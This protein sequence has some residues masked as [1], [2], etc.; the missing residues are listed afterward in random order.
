MT[1]PNNAKGS[2][3]KDG[4]GRYEKG[5]NE[6]RKNVE[7]E[8]KNIGSNGRLVMASGVSPDA[9]PPA[10]DEN[11]ANEG[12]PGA[13]STTTTTTT[14]S[15]EQGRGS[16]DETTTTAR[17]TAGSAT[18]GSHRPHSADETLVEAQMVVQSDDDDDNIDDADVEASMNDQVLLQETE[19]QIRQR[20]LQEEGV[21]VDDVVVMKDDNIIRYGKGKGSGG[22]QSTNKVLYL[23]TILIVIVVAAIVVPTTVV[24]LGNNE[25]KKSENSI[26]F[27]DLTFREQV[28]ETLRPMYNNNNDNQDRNDEGENESKGRKM[29]F[30]NRPSID[31]VHEIGT[32]QNLAF[33]WIVNTMNSLHDPPVLL[34]DRYD[35][36]NI[37][38]LR[39]EENNNNNGAGGG[40]NTSGIIVDDETDRQIKQQLLIERYVM[41]LIY[42][43]TNSSTWYH[44]FGFME[45]TKTVC[46]WFM[47]RY[48]NDDQG[49]VG[50]LEDEEIASTT[51]SVVSDAFFE[52]TEQ[53]DGDVEEDD[54]DNDDAPDRLEIGLQRLGVGFCH[55]ENGSI[56]SMFMWGNNLMGTIPYELSWLT[57]IHHIDF[58]YNHLTGTIPPELF[59][60]SLPNMDFASFAANQL[61]GP[62]PSSKLNSVDSE[63]DEF[64]GGGDGYLDDAYWGDHVRKLEILELQHNQL[65]G[66]IPASLAAAP[67]LF[68]LHFGVNL[69]TGTIPDV[70]SSSQ[71]FLAKIVLSYNLLSGPAI[72]ASVTEL[73]LLRQ[74]SV[75]DN[76]LEGTIPT[77][78][79]TWDDLEFLVL[80]NNL[81]GGSLP[82]EIGLLQDLKYVTLAINEFTGS[83][84]SEVGLLEDLIALHLYNNKFTGTISDETFDGA[85]RT[86]TDMRISENQF[87]GTLPSSLGRMTSLGKDYCFEQIRLWERECSIDFVILTNRTYTCI[88]AITQDSY[89]FKIIASLWI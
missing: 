68:S 79:S 47:Q 45:E 78:I 30:L 85:V 31:I 89:I 62:L 87:S 50:V 53:E 81:M 17:S 43:S 20:I 42:F 72:P 29:N 4:N 13:F 63:G 32:P 55:P 66:T 27:N 65:S 25:K 80:Q 15:V 44:P 73:S 54:D 12:Q 1:N 16:E 46:L 14:T 60:G 19:E 51:S 28:L 5:A 18:E 52:T 35:P 61:S 57:N 6:K 26:N 70:F 84:P 36:H 74:Y 67:N 40:T 49:G 7:E 76:L 33:E 8:K 69:L 59:D 48:S 41:A 77:S 37:F 88:H 10:D 82:T 21:Q 2:I 75:N 71:G 34:Y 38:K 39:D 23:G 24:I 3:H 83:L 56:A 11:A 64:D 9:P 22:N 86:M 58:S